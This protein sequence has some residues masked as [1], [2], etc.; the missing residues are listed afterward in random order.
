MCFNPFCTLPVWFNTTFVHSGELCCQTALQNVPKNV[1]LLPPNWHL[2]QRLLQ[3]SKHPRHDLHLKVNIMCRPILFFLWQEFGQIL[4]SSPT[5]RK[6]TEFQLSTEGAVDLAGL[7]FVKILKSPCSVIPEGES[8]NVAAHPASVT[9]HKE[10]MWKQ[11]D[12]RSLHI[13]QRKTVLL[14]SSSQYFLSYSIPSIKWKMLKNVIYR[15]KKS[16]A[17]STSFPALEK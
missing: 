16:T 11:R 15:G 14:C 7:D 1:L 10:Q 5:R 13:T 17:T 2:P 12:I 8:L 6:S 4:H 9:G 3:Q